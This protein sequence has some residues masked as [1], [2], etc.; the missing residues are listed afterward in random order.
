MVSPVLQYSISISLSLSLSLSLDIVCNT[1]LGQE[2][3]VH[4]N[5]STLV[6]EGCNSN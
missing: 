1:Y 3:Y 2:A 4:N 5:Y 6:F